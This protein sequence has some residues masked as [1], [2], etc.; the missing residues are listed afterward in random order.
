MVEV[1]LYSKYR[2]LFISLKVIVS[3]TEH[4]VVTNEPDVLFIE[5]VNFFV[6]SYLVNACTYLESF[7]QDYAF[8]YAVRINS[9]LKGV[10][11][12]YNF[13]YWMISK[14][15]KD[16]DLKFICADFKIN[17]KSISEEISANP[18]KTIK[19]FRLLGVNLCSSDVFERLKDF[20]NG[21]VIKRNNIIH[22]N[23][24]ALDIS[25]SDINS[26]IDVFLE[27]MRAITDVIEVNTN[28]T[29]YQSA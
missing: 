11:I 29:K 1:D 2:D 17:K 16:K 19:L 27:Y 14:D 8:N 7:L 20:V 12:P 28:S 21:V 15:I 18:Y 13:L 5:N 23:D 22:H 3:E 6:K 10:E 26:Y 4:R 9:K 25:F 24:D